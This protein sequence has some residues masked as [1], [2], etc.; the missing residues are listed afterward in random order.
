V[1]LIFLQAAEGQ[2]VFVRPD[3]ESGFLFSWDSA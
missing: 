2:G 1:G 3:R